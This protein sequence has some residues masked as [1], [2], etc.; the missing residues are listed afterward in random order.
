MAITSTKYIDKIIHNN[1]EY[2]LID[3]TAD[4]G[5]GGGSGTITG[6]VAGTGLSG[7]GTSGSIT[8]NHANTAI[9]PQSTQ[10]LYP[11]AFDNQGHITGY[12][13]AI[14]PLTAT[15]ILDATKL[16]GTIPTSCYL[17]N[18]V[19]QQN[20]SNSNK[21]YRILLSA[22]D[23]DTTQTDIT[24]KSTGLLFNPS[25]NTLTTNITTTRVDTPNSSGYIMDQYGNFVCKNQTPS[26]T[27][28]WNLKTYNNTA[29]FKIFWNSGDVQTTG[30]FIGT[31]IDK[32]FLKLN[33]TASSSTNIQVG[34]SANSY[35]SHMGSNEIWFHN[36][37]GSSAYHTAL[38]SDKLFLGMDASNTG[39]AQNQAI[40]DRSSLTFEVSNTSY[41]L[42]YTDIYKLHS[43]GTKVV[44]STSK[45]ITGTTTSGSSWTNIDSWD[46][47]ANSTWVAHIYARF[48]A[49]STGVR[50]LCLSETSGAAYAETS[51]DNVRNNCILTANSGKYTYIHITTIV[52]NTTSA[53]KTFFINCYHTAG[54]STSL[55]TSAG[56]DAIRVV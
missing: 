56:Y 37:S 14:T 25:T 21:N 32:T 35:Y 10:G 26:S 36:T 24:Q 31:N 9:T 43:I 5:S 3:S 44:H 29:F 23:N 40:L 42:N 45:S 18:A 15:S 2:I 1:T 30:A 28:C 8:I 41:K 17:N 53:V 11:I 47:P 13:A 39:N 54:T 50:A 48:A 38:R 27:S 34:S 19:T 22:N 20:V 49:N 7:G 6:V 51:A 4:H 52:Q 16:N 55:T 33:Q 46:V 12:S